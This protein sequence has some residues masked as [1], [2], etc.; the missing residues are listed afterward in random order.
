VPALGVVLAL[1]VS[2]VDTHAASRCI[3]VELKKFE[4]PDAPSIGKEVSLANENL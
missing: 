3:S 4:A 1:L 2:A